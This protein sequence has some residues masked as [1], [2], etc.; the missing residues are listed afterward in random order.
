MFCKATL[1]G[2]H[3]EKF[4]SV[5]GKAQCTG[6]INWLAGYKQIIHNEM[7]AL[8]VTIGSHFC[9]QVSVGPAV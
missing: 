8:L 2:G 4:V 5:T 3:T 6:S 1:D 9:H 7:S